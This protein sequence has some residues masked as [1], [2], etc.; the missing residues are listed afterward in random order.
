MIWMQSPNSLANITEHK[1][2]L[3]CK[4][5]R[6]A[7]NKFQVLHE[8]TQTIYYNS[9]LHSR[10]VQEEL[11]GQDSREVSVHPATEKLWRNLQFAV[12]DCFYKPVQN[13]GLALSVRQARFRSFR[14]RG[15][16]LE[17]PNVQIP[18][19]APRGRLLWRLTHGHDSD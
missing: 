3:P 2:P 8:N 10:E 11:I 5:Q 19:I 4:L 7:T 16:C 1:A 13:L 12:A 6:Q 15:R 14:R 9:Q 17:P 18:L